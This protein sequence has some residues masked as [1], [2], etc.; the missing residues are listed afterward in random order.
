[1][2][3]DEFKKLLEKNWD[4]EEKELVIRIMDG[5]LYYKRFLPKAF[6]DDVLLAIKLCNKLKNELENIKDIKE[7]EKNKQ[8]DVIN[9]ILN[10]ESI[11]IIRENLINCIKEIDTEKNIEINSLKNDI[12]E[13]KMIIL[14]DKKAKKSIKYKMYKKILKY[15]YKNISKK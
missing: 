1:M 12:E 14:I 13:L 11:K 7:N 9:D 10:T 4:I 6:K 15:I 2:L 8:N 5:L 3:E